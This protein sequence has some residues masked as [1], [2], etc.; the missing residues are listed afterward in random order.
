MYAR[1][2]LASVHRQSAPALRQTGRRDTILQVPAEQDAIRTDA[3][4]QVAVLRNSEE[5]PTVVDLAE[6]EFRFYKYADER[7]TELHRNG[8]E[9]RLAVLNWEKH[10][11][12]AARAL[13]EVVF[14]KS[15]LTHLGSKCPNVD[16]TMEAAAVAADL[17][18]L[19]M[20][21]IFRRPRDV[22][23]SSIGRR[24]RARQGMDVWPITN[25]EAASRA[26]MVDW[27]CAHLARK[28]LGDRILSVK[29]EDLIEGDEATTDLIAQHLGVDNCF[30]TSVF[31]PLPADLHG[32]ALTS[33]EA[34]FVDLALG[35]ISAAWDDPLPVLF[36]AYPRIG[37][38]LQK[39]EPILFAEGGNSGFFD[40]GGFSLSESWGTWTDGD[41]ARLDIK[42]VDAD[43]D[44]LVTLYF[45]V[46]YTVLPDRPF[47]FI[48]SAG[49][50]RELVTIGPET[51][52]SG[53]L[54]RQSVRIARQALDHL[55][56]FS[57]EFHI[58][59]PKET[60]EEPLS[61]R[62]RLGL[63]LVRIDI[64]VVGN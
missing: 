36:N 53:G 43:G 29:Y 59:R 51:L 44:V 11:A 16:L 21:H 22:V 14:G 34:T 23:N 25:V 56:H 46:W 41:C 50:W 45:N 40:G 26:W 35:D 9:H 58:L 4:Q 54:Y 8:L 64:G 10:G 3:P 60:T 32:Y 5:L 62:R 48:L 31:R 38:P 33:E 52:G 19:R 27:N 1:D 42:R 49:R 39:E 24:N 13:F 17:P 63:G 61:D 30:D 18:N 2:L 15:R 37:F 12:R 6:S 55:P 47:K 20:L 28:V 57:L 7:D